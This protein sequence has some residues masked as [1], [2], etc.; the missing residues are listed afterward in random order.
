MN[1]SILEFND[2]AEK[3]LKLLGDSFGIK[4]IDLLK[5]NT[6]RDIKYKWFLDGLSILDKETGIVFNFELYKSKRLNIGTEEKLTYFLTEI[7]FNINHDEE[8]HNQVI[9]NKVLLFKDVFDEYTS[10]EI[11]KKL[12]EPHREFKFLVSGKTNF[13]E[14]KLK[15]GRY[16]FSFCEYKGKLKNIILLLE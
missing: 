14:Y 8:Y 13:I 3:T 11:K 1:T 9:F 4:K 10:S 6:D 15:Q 7:V 16:Q 5:Q 12:G 2:R